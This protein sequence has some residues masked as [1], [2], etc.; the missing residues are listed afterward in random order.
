[1][2]TLMGLS[3]IPLYLARSITD[4]I[5]TAVFMG[6]ALAGL[7]L[8]PLHGE[9]LQEVKRLPKEKSGGYL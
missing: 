1:L 8:Y 6:I 9:R 7:L 4:A 2:H 5:S 3:T